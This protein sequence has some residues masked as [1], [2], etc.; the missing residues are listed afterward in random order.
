VASLGDRYTEYLGPEAYRAALRRPLAGELAYAAARAA[1]GVGIVV[2]G[3]SSGN[4]GGKFGSFSNFNGSSGARVAAVLAESTAEAAG[5]EPGDVLLEVEGH[6]AARLGVEELDALLRGPAGSVARV[7]VLKQQQQ[8]QQP[9][10]GLGGERR[11]SP[12]HA[13][14][15]S[16]SSLPSSAPSPRTT[17]TLDLER[18]PIPQPPVKT[19]LLLSPRGR[20]VAYVR[21][22]YFSRDASRALAGALVNAEARGDEGLVLD[23]RN[24]PGGVFEE[25]LGNAAM[26]L[27]RGAKIASTTRTP[28]SSSSSSSSSSSPPP[29]PPPAATFVAGD[30]DNESSPSFLRRAALSSAPMAVLVDAGSASGAEV[31]AGALADN[32]RAVTVGPRR[33]FGKGLIQYYFL[34]GDDNE[35][36]GGSSSNGGGGDDSG[37]GGGVK[38]TGKMFFFSFS[39]PVFFSFFLQKTCSHSLS[40]SHSLLSNLLLLLPTT[41]SRRLLHSQRPRPLGRGRAR[42]AEGLHRARQRSARLDLLG[43]LCFSFSLLLPGRCRRRCCRGRRRRLP[44]RGAAGRGRRDRQGRRWRRGGGAG[45]VLRERERVR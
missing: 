15:L 11:F 7:V 23:L 6:A 24:N 31:L 33:T 34:V 13:A 45:S 38:V 21:L 30:L 40:L 29:P 44:A 12:F 3:P 9:R 10:G 25:A 17:L 14:L 4:G 43:F 36:K 16:S 27:P 1:G 20:S 39:R 35:K 28:A 5:V 42:A 19:A 22:H 37:V 26:L 8:Q 2:E 18:R 41:N 32:G